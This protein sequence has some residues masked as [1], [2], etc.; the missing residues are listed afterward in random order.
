MLIV[1]SWRE[2]LYMLAPKQAKMLIFV[3]AKNLSDL[4]Y[5]RLTYIIVVPLVLGISFGMAYAD[6]PGFLVPCFLVSLV[7]NLF[8]VLLLL[9]VRPSVMIKHR[10]YFMHYQRHLA[11]VFVFFGFIN[12]IHA[13]CPL[14]WPGF[15][16]LFW[17]PLSTLWLLF[18]I[19]S[20]ATLDAFVRSLFRAFLML[21]YNLPIF[22]VVTV[23]WYLLFAGLSQWPILFLSHHIAMQREFWQF[24]SGAL[25]GFILFPLW[26]SVITTL[27]VKQLHE[28]FAVYFGRPLS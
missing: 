1:E 6:H 24:F 26:Y 22:L 13:F 2:S 16:W 4:V 18:F 9:L 21:V 15:I 14:C 7:V 27:Y 11:Y 23:F 10:Y 25:V 5:R 12:L 8:I 20:H 28:Q 19:D 3:T 17:A